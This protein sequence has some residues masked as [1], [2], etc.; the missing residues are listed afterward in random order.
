M[1]FIVCLLGVFSLLLL[2]CIGVIHAYLHAVNEPGHKAPD[3]PNKARIRA[4]EITEAL[5]MV[6]PTMLAEERKAREGF[7]SS[8]Q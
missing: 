1:C 6:L 2:A 3:C 7:P 8:Q 4:A 5:K